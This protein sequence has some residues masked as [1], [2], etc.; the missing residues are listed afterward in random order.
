MPSKHI[1]QVTSGQVITFDQ[2]DLNLGNAYG[3]R[4]GYFKAPYSGTYIFSMTLGNPEGKPGGFFL[5]HNGKAIEFIFAGQTSG[6][7]MGGATTVAELLVGDEVWVEGEGH[8]SRSDERRIHTSFSGVLL[9]VT[10]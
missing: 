8:I 4:P 7:D 10:Y 2:I 3:T 5:V 1:G 9:H 6:W